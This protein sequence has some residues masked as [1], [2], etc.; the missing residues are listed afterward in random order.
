M[1]LLSKVSTTFMVLACEAMA[2]LPDC[3][4]TH[5]MMNPVALHSFPPITE[6]LRGPGTLLTPN[7]YLVKPNSIKRW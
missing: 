5:G 1:A 6:F 3:V 2:K 7:E 4:R